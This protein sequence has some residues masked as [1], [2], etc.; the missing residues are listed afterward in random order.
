MGDG[1]ETDLAV[2]QDQGKTVQE[3]EDTAGSGNGVHE[4]D[5]GFGRGSSAFKSSMD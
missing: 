5:S 1:G 4:D 2:L 3:G